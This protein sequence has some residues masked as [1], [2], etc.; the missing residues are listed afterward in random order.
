MSRVVAI[1]GGNR[2]IGQTLVNKFSAQGDK[3]AVL[4]AAPTQDDEIEEILKDSGG[5]YFP[6]DI[7][8]RL[9]VNVAVSDMEREMGPVDVLINNV[10]I[11]RVNDFI[12]ITE[13]EWD[14][15]FDVNVK[16]LL[17]VTQ[18]VAR[19]MIARQQGTIV[20]IASMAGK[21]GMVGRG[22]YGATK[23][24]VIQLTKV[25]ALELG[26][27]N[28][29]VNSVCPGILFTEAGMPNLPSLGARREWKDKSALRRLG[30][31]DE[32]ASVV[33]FLASPAAEYMTG[34]ALNVTGGMVM[35]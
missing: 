23:A 28:I 33:A 30:T 31:P 2:G 20:N 11:L 15:M 5:R 6:C 4:D 13:D 22:A 34:Q 35:D 27:H 29:R 8:D 21:I 26:P 25:L 32:V 10:G 18:P 7:R 16:G 3:V 24:A 14:L 12:N 19:S 17:F 1:T 9:Q